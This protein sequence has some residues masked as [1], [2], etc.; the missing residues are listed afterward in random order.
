MLVLL[1]FVSAGQ[2]DCQRRKPERLCG[3]N[4]R[5]H[6]AEEML[7]DKT[8]VQMLPYNS[9]QGVFSLAFKMAGMINY[10]NNFGSLSGLG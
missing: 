1:H 9:N 7:P 8:W 3:Q 10:M 5:Q 4:E 6:L 2:G